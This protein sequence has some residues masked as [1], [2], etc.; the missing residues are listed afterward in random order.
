MKIKKSL[1]SVCLS[2]SLMFGCFAPS[3]NVYASSGESPQINFL[4]N[5]WNK[6][7]SFTAGVITDAVDYTADF[8]QWLTSHKSDYGISS[9]EDPDEWVQRNVDIDQSGNVTI[10]DNVINSMRDCVNNYITND[11]DLIYGYSYSASDWH[12]RFESETLFQSFVNVL[13]DNK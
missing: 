2:I 13:A 4:K 3:I 6:T 12:V 10:S 11:S 1:L 8:L 7:V 9:N 5:H